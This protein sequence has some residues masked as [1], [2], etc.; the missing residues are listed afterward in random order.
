MREKA[1]RI[2]QWSIDYQDPGDLEE[3]DTMAHAIADEWLDCM[4]EY[5]GR[6][7]A[8]GRP[9]PPPCFAGDVLRAGA[10]AIIAFLRRVDG[11]EYCTRHGARPG[12]SLVGDS[13]G[14][15]GLPSPVGE[16]T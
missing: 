14:D 3:R 10:Q 9:Q 6:A 2:A 7:L 4:N 13:A 8:E 5:I 15:S 1:R 11:L 12:S 16:A